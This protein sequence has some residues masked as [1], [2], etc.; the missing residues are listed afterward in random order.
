LNGSLAAI[1]ESAKLQSTVQMKNSM[2]LFAEYPDVGTQV[3]MSILNE[4]VS[5]HAGKETNGWLGGAV[6]K[7]RGSIKR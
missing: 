1:T 2:R 7:R 4:V 3:V 5:K 6:G